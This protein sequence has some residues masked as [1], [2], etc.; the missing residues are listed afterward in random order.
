MLD[1][2]T[3]TFEYGKL[4]VIKGVSG[5]GKTTWLNIMGGLDSDY[6]G[7]VLLDGEN[8]KAVLTEKVGYV[9]QQSLLISA[10]IYFS[11]HF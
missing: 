7:E 11:V 6:E 2:V 4:Y 5:C 8:G 3:H 9:F 1:G 10:V